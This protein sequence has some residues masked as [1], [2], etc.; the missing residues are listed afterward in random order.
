MTRGKAA[1]EPRHEG[2]TPKEAVDKLGGKDEVTAMERCTCTNDPRHCARHP[3]VF[4]GANGRRVR[5]AIS[6]RANG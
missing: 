4:E 5:A 1:K 6:R 2:Q 3:Y